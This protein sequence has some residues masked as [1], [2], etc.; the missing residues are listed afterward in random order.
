[1]RRGKQATIDARANALDYRKLAAINAAA[2]ANPEKLVNHAEVRKLDWQE[3]QAK[4]KEL[5][6]GKLEPIDQA[7]LMIYQ[8]HQRNLERDMRRA[9]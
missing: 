3:T 5:Y 2:K 6:A 7:N 8:A 9:A 1:M 4:I